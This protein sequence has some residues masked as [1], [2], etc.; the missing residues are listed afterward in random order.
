MPSLASLHHSARQSIWLARLALLSRILLAIG[1]I[2]AGLVKVL[3]RRFTTLPDDATAVGRFFEALYQTGGYWQFLGWAQV[4]AGGCLLVPR[5]AALG[6][7]CFLPIMLNIFVIT[8]ALPFTGTPWVTGSMLLA[9]VFL[10]LWD[11][12]RWC[13]LL[14]APAA[15]AAGRAG[16]GERAALGFGTL[17]GLVV[18][19]GM[20]GLAPAGA[21]VPALFVGAGAAVAL[22][23]AWFRTGA[24]T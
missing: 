21:V 16:R 3:G 20:R 18:F 10:V 19:L 2:P 8:L 5:T 23:V 14:G 17:C 4:V 11:Y 15:Q 13:G 6:A 9:V 1:F 12:P 7:V 22:L 24:R